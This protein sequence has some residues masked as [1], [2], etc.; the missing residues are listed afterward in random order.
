M[1]KIFAALMLV[2][3]SCV[4]VMAWDGFDYNSGSPVEIEQGNL[5]RSGQTI[6]YFDHA[7]GNYSTGDVIDVT[8]YG[9]SVEVEVYDLNSGENRT[10]DM[11]GN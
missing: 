2:L 9:N 1:K 6:E 10:F 3:L 4:S 8:R 11:D 7:T 5:V